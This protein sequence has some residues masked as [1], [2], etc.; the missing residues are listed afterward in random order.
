MLPVVEPGFN[1]LRLNVGF[2]T[3]HYLCQAIPQQSPKLFST[4]A[5][6]LKPRGHEASLGSAW[7][8]EALE[9]I[10]DDRD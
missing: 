1:R 4:E 2:S 8:S 6:L 3:G 10:S 7:H 5:D 9:S